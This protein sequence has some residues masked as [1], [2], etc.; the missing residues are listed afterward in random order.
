MDL[1]VKMWTKIAHILFTY[2]FNQIR[3]NHSGVGLN[4]GFYKMGLELLFMIDE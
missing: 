3:H 4:S 1:Y 2:L